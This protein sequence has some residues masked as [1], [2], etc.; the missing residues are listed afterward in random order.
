MQTR[1][2]PYSLVVSKMENNFTS[3]TYFVQNKEGDVGWIRTGLGLPPKIVVLATA[4]FN[5]TDKVWLKKYRD[6]PA[7]GLSLTTD[8]PELFLRCESHNVGS[9]QFGALPQFATSLVD[10]MGTDFLSPSINTP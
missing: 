6:S 5:S 1:L 8:S 10:S 7:A 9:L 2:D 4:V 3:K